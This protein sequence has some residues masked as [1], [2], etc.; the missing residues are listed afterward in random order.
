MTSKTKILFF[1][2]GIHESTREYRISVLVEICKKYEGI[3]KFETSVLN[4]FDFL[5]NSG[6]EINVLFDIN[7]M[8]FVFIHH[9]FNLPSAIPSNCFDILK[10]KLKEKLIVFSGDMPINIKEGKLRRDDVYCNF[11]K[12]LEIHDLIG[13]WYLKAFTERNVIRNLADY[14]LEL[15]RNALEK[16]LNSSFFTKEFNNIS[17][18]I[19]VDID[20]LKNH[21]IEMDE[22]SIMEYLETKIDLL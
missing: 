16:D 19:R 4:Y 7:E 8:D 9:S 12:F 5:D 2:E 21:L 11:I 22:L 13:V 10:Q 15:Y 18:L 14:N 6:N 3:I 17:S 1:D 20:I